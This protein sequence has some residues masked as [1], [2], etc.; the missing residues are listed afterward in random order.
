MAQ[1]PPA[2]PRGPTV[3][4][5]E[6]DYE[7]LKSQESRTGRI[8]AVKAAPDRTSP[9][10]A[11]LVPGNSSLAN[12]SYM[13]QEVNNGF[14]HIKYVNF[15][16][17]PECQLELPSGLSI[18]RT[19][20]NTYEAFY[21]V[22]RTPSIRGE[23]LFERM[24]ETI[25]AHPVLSKR[26]YC[27]AQGDGWVPA[28]AVKRVARPGDINLPLEKATKVKPCRDCEV[29]SPQG[30]PG[31]LVETVREVQQQVPNPIDDALE[32][33]MKDWPGFKKF[34]NE[35]ENSIGQCLLPLPRGV[36]DGNAIDYLAN[37]IRL[38]QKP[39]P[40]YWNSKGQLVSVDKEDQFAI[41]LLMRVLWAEMHNCA[42]VAPGSD[43]TED[44]VDGNKIISPGT[45]PGFHPQYFRAVGRII[46]N[47]Y[48][49]TRQPEV[50]PGARFD[51]T[52]SF[53]PSKEWDK[54]LGKWVTVAPEN[55]YLGSRN[56]FLR[57]VVKEQDPQ[58]DPI[59]SRALAQ[60][61]LD[62]TEFS[63]LDF[64]RIKPT[65]NSAIEKVLCPGGRD[66]DVNTMQNLRNA[67]ETA[68]EMLL[69]PERFKSS[70]NA[71]RNFDAFTSSVAMPGN[72]SEGNFQNRNLNGEAISNTACI[73]VYTFGGGRYKEPR[74]NEDEALE[75]SPTGGKTP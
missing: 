23:E 54:R 25:Q 39:L 64:P 27:F 46:S 7:I 3:F 34:F 65:M 50:F 36:T 63:P 73:R 59:A 75:R 51:Y 62:T 17:T 58:G 30:K 31:Q 28:N 20:I 47:R 18:R 14:V 24:Q 69:E 37:R 38:T 15:P 19:L 4:Q 22:R 48:D 32:R 53:L 60:V 35:N 45:P 44:N 42:H 61:L 66:P 12:F 1:Q 74:T 11:W 68:M 21:N 6:S 5:R 41:E 57:T 40:P 72:P 55:R 52:S 71:L 70:T 43:K 8:L 2:R 49:V 67:K 16:N 29:K 33:Y 56:P 9:G 10:K 26:P 13:G